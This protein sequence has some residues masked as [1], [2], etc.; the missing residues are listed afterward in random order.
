[1][2][3]E[4]R[5]IAYAYLSDCRDFGK[6]VDDTLMLFSTRKEALRQ[7]EGDAGKPVRVSVLISWP[8]IGRA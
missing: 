4:I 3:G 8:P 6:V 2:N 1:M 5:R 7:S